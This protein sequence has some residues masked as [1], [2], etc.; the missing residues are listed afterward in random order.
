MRKNSSM[1]NAQ[2][3][4]I[5][6]G[7]ITAYDGKEYYI[8]DAP[9]KFKSEGIDSDNKLK[10]GDFVNIKANEFAKDRYVIDEILPRTNSLIRPSVS[11]LEQLVIVVAPLPKPDLNLVDALIIYCMQYNIQP[12]LVIN[13]SDIAKDEFIKE[14]T[15]QYGDVVED[16]LVISAA[17]DK[18]ID[19]LKEKLS[20][21]LSAF[22]GQSAVG[23]SSIINALSDEL[24]L[25]VQQLSKKINRGKHTTRTTE[26]YILDDMKLA[27][28][29]G[30]SMLDITVEQEDIKHFY[31]DFTKFSKDCKY[32]SCNHINAKREDCGVVAAVQNG[33]LSEDRYNRYLRFFKKGEKVW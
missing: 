31:T 25:K 26:I 20:G 19:K 30:F 32:R 9:G 28:T 2:I 4:K 8:C 14:I 21:K 33:D 6:K 27:D 16:I 13:K 5:L 23:K 11:N 24:N 15:F 3:L 12:L 1:K 29:P 22:A 7:N 18:E 10:V 17:K